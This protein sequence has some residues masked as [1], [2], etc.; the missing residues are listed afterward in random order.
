MRAHHSW[1]QQCLN[2]MASCIALFNVA[3]EAKSI[4]AVTTLIDIFRGN[5]ITTLEN[6]PVATPKHTSGLHSGLGNVDSKGAKS[7]EGAK[8]NGDRTGST[9][10]TNFGIRST[11][12]DIAYSKPLEAHSRQEG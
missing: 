9:L 4:H 3:C 5:Q 8:I 6:A 10:D 1:I 7:D 2:L 12:I 11:A